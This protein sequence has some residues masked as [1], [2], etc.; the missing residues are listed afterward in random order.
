MA[1]VRKLKTGEHGVIG[2]IIGDSFSDDPINQWIFGS[3]H[4]IAGYYTL[5]AK[6]LYLQRGYGHVLDNSGGTLWLPPG[7]AK[8]IPLWNSLDI[9][10]IMLRQGGM[11]ALLRG[12]AVDGYLA[13]IKPKEAHHYLF[14]IGARQGCQ[15]K[16]IGGKLMAAGL[17]RANIECMPVYLESSKK[18]N[19]PFY[20]RFGFELLEE[21]VPAK[22]CPPMWPMWREPG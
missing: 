9:A 17:E 20:R 14:A 8:H 15:G 21:V 22:G 12:L 6:K 1:T 7:V 16:G 5:A 2:D 18:E 13:R 19:I 10:A 4:G 3:T 11:G